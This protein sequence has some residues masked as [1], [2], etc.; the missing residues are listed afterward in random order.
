M[1]QELVLAGSQF[2]PEAAQ[3]EILAQNAAAAR[4]GL[5]LTLRDAQELTERRRQAL[6]KTG[7]IEFGCGAIGPLIDAFSDSA[8]LSPQTFAQTLAELQDAFYEAKNECADRMTDAEHIA[9]MRRCFDG[10]AQGSVEWLRGTW[11]P[12]LCHAARAGAAALEAWRQDEETQ[13]GRAAFQT[14]LQ[15]YAAEEE[16]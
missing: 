9:A 13:T 15:A 2:S 11:L 12:A 14:L 7:R 6:L 8:Y 5:A 3:Q 4:Y 1:E 10:A 16:A